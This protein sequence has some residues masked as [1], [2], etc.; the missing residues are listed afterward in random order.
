READP[1]AVARQGGSGSAPPP[2]PPF[3]Q[4]K[5]PRP[6]TLTMVVE[7]VKAL[8]ERKGS[9]AAALKHYILNRY[10]GVDPIRLKYTLKK[11][12]AK[13]LEEG[14]LARPQNSTAHGATGRFKVRG[15]AGWA[16]AGVGTGQ[17]QVPSSSPSG[18]RDPPKAA[19]AQGPPGR[20]GQRAQGKRG[21]CRRRPQGSQRCSQT[22]G[23]GG[24]PP[25]QGEAESERGAQQGH[26]GAQG[27][28][29]E[30]G[31]AQSSRQGQLRTP[32]PA[33]WTA[34]SGGRKVTQFWGGFRS[35]ASLFYSVFN[36]SA[37][38]PIKLMLTKP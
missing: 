14:Y 36:H 31:R 27:G 5:T 24:A 26:Q 12:L 35:K 19:R 11:A 10:P 9:S 33:P 7:A 16:P 2:A 18:T 23:G 21:Q 30:V 32:R 34:F 28:R 25:G 6:P 29:C 38:F 22:E 1:T 17:P 13:G 8:N 37:F 4:S 15:G 3:G 20:P